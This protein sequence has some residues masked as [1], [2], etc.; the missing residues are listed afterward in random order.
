MKRYLV[1]VAIVVALI[2]LLVATGMA[3]KDADKHSWL[4]VYTQSVDYDIAEAFD[5]DVRYGAVVNLVVDD[6]PADKAGLREDDVIIAFN[7]EKVTDSDDLVD[8]LIETKPGDNVT[9]TVI[10]DGKEQNVAVEVGETPEQEYVVR[11]QRGVP[12]VMYFS[13][14]PRAYVGVYLDDLSEQLGDYFG[15]ADGEGALITEVE[16]D[17]PAQKAGLKAGDVIVQVEGEKILE[18]DDVGEVIE[19]Y[20]EGDRVNFTVVRDQRQSQI[21]VEITERKGSPLGYNSYF[22]PDRAVINIPRMHGL[23]NGSSSGWFD[24]EAEF[25]EEFEAE[26]RQLAEEMARLKIEL[27]DI[28]KVEIDRDGIRRDLEELRRELREMKREMESELRELNERKQ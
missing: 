17:S 27:K 11:G 8:L 19:D 24:F 15:V 2:A 1:P 21:T 3:R 20:K 7:N 18:A 6:S 16:K 25:G 14:G 26:M 10:R 23:F 22:G 13:A 4:G 5:L 9:L 28:D 12:D